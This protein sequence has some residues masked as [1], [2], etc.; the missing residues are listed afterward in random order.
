LITSTWATSEAR[1]RVLVERSVAIPISDGITLDCDIFRPDAE[2]CYPVIVSAAPYSLQLQSAPVR[3]DAFSSIGAE[4]RGEK[5][6]NSVMEAGDPWFYAR[7]GYVHIILNVRGTGRSGGVYGLMDD[8]EV[9]DVVEAIEWAA[10]QP[11]ST[12]AVGMFGVSYFAMIQ[13]RV[14]AKQPPSLKCLFAPF[15][16]GSFR[17]LIFHGGVLN[18]RWLAGWAPLLTEAN[19]RIESLSVS[20][21]GE[22]LFAKKV[23]EAL[24]DPDIAADP[25]AAAALRNPTEGV[26]ALLTDIMLHLDDGPFW[27]QRRAQY[28]NIEVPIYMGA[29]WGNYGIH[30]AP[31]FP[32]WD[33]VPHP[34][35]MVVGP[36]MYLDRPVAQLQYES[37]RWFDQ[38]LKGIDTGVRDD[39]AVQVFST[40][41]HDWLSGPEW[42][43]PETRWTPLR[44][45][46][47]GVLSE[48]DPWWAEPHDAFFDS[49]FNRESVDYWAPQFV[50]N[51]QLVGPLLLDMYAAT[52]DTNIRWV[53]SVLARNA[54]GEQRLLTKSVFDG[55]FRNAVI[56]GSDAWAPRYDFAAPEDVPPLEVQRYRI[57]VIPTAH[58]FSPGT[59]LGVRIGC[60]TV[61][62]PATS[63]EGAASGH[64]RSQTPARITIHHDESYPSALWAPITAGNIFGTYLSGGVGYVD[65]AG[66]LW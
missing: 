31:L 22:E 28:E 16:S 15:G 50:D 63:L 53:V 18:A 39:P 38:W 1:Y 54:G 46:E 56:P 49:P 10:A 4:A 23:A 44:L 2:G 57:P 40:G 17:D 47:R 55:R 19:A 6:P 32:A 7:R 30:L 29:C 42:P 62:E 45:H 14:G 61:D 13:H 48:R 8:Q 64:L 25:A 20:E 3:P 37:L 60:A 26:S 66:G 52:S 34:K 12:G 51:V 58:R 43:L 35:R 59:Q 36:P 9:D 65:V 41:S 21:F 33:R 27:E 5:R 24:A 11:W